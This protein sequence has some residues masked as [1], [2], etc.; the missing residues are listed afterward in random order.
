M[1]VL[2]LCSQPRTLFTAQA[3]A[4]V[5]PTTQASSRRE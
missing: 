2:P 5:P 3:T 1:N 4:F